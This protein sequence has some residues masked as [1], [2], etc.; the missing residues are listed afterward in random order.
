MNRQQAKARFAQITQVRP[1]SDDLYQAARIRPEIS[2]ALHH[3][4]SNAINYPITANHTEF[5]LLLV[6]YLEA[7]AGITEGK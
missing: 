6:E 3:V 4:G 7:Y 5:W 1:Y 2:C